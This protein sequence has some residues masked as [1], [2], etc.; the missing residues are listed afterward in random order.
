[1]VGVT[2]QCTVQVSV[3]THMEMEVQSCLLDIHESGVDCFDEDATV[4][5]G[6]FILLCILSVGFISF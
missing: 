6:E 4:V 3:H 2:M 1:M 5:V